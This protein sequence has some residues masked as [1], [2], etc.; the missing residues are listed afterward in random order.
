MVHL[1]LILVGTALVLGS[2]DVPARETA[3]AAATTVPAPAQDDDNLPPVGRSLFDALLERPAAGG[4]VVVPF[5]FAALLA[6][7]R[8]ELDPKDPSGGLSV[9]LI[10]LGRSL[11]RNAAFDARPFDFPRVVAAVT[12]EPPPGARP[13]HPYLRDRLY[14]GYHEGAGVLEV[15]SYNEEAGRFE[16]QVVRDYRSGAGP[17]QAGGS[18]PGGQRS[19]G[20]HPPGAGPPQAGARPPGGQRSVGPETAGA[21]PRPRYANRSL[22]LACH[23]NAAPIFSRPGWDETSANAQVAARLAATGREFHGLAWRH[24]VDVPNAIDDATD[25]ANLLAVAQRLWREGCTAG[26]AADAV[27]CRATA[28]KLS[29]RYRLAGGRTVDL[30]A[31]D[32]RRSFVEPLLARWQARWPGGLAIPNPDLPNR[33]VLDAPAPGE[34]AD[35]TALARRAD[36]GAGFDPMVPRPALAVWPGREDTDVTAFIHAL[37]L[38]FSRADVALLDRRLAALAGGEGRSLEL[39]CTERRVQP[40]GDPARRDLEC[41]AAGGAR[42]L[43]RLEGAG[44]SLDELVLPGGER[45][46]A[47]ELRAVR[48]AG[49]AGKGGRAASGRGEFA[50]AGEEAFVVSGDDGGARTAGG[51]VVRGMGLRRAAGAATAARL[52]LVADTGPLERAIDA[53]AADTLSGRGD[54]LGERPLRRAAVLG[55]IFAHLGTPA[56]G[57]PKPG[58]APSGGSAAWGPTSPAPGRPKPGAAPSGGS[59]AWGLNP[60][61]PVGARPTGRSRPDAADLQPFYRRCAA[62]HDAPE[63]FPPGFL[64]GNEGQVRASL[65]GCA[66]RILFR[67]AMNALPAAGRTKTPMPPP[68]SAQ[69]AGFAASSDLAAMRRLLEAPAGTANPENRRLSPVWPVVAGGYALLPPCRPRLST[70]EVSLERR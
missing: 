48:G 36:V 2:G 60:P 70:P 38:F 41:G 12:G 19:V 13:G 22:C 46:A 8:R 57:R 53:L 65:A 4:E 16:F 26:V 61:A 52:T 23:H 54:A 50:V 49:G 10:P 47:L 30:S 68:V 63:A 37:S 62:C 43:A 44:G 25:R 59:A 14:L 56:P 64:H 58:A 17:P 55:P 9:V 33:Q 31:P 15:I 24:G 3:G 27:G 39:A 28:L 69:A 29:L 7:I 51:E 5:P 18:P 42:L 1:A 67:L 66:P 21:G 6:R 20:A 45:L 11:Q 40:P 34:P 35:P 32:L